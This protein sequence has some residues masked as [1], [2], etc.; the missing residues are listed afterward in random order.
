MPDPRRLFVVHGRNDHFRS[1]IFQFL[2]AIG[3]DP[4][5]WNEA[6]GMTQN[7]SPFIGEVLDA[8][9]SQA[10]AVLV[11]LTGDDEARMVQRK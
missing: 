4:I 3:L 2:R 6:V 9:L 1:S 8:A 7:P 11:L 5:E 10:Q